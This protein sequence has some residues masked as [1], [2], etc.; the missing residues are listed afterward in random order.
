MGTGCEGHQEAG[1]RSRGAGSPVVQVPGRLKPEQ[2][3]S[4][5]PWRSAS[6]QSHLPLHLSCPVSPCLFAQSPARGQS[7]CLCQPVRLSLSV[8]LSVSQPFTLRISLS[9]CQPAKSLSLSVCPSAVSTSLLVFCFLSHSRSLSPSGLPL[10][11]TATQS[12]GAIS[13]ML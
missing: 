9:I 12:K 1:H 8:F 2:H 4:L 10:G 11:D 3:L 5:S 13:E 6:F 7:V